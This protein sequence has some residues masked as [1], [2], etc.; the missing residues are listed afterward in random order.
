MKT[1]MLAAVAALALTSSAFA[2]DE[3]MA[4]RFGNTTKVTYP[5]NMV[6]KIWY[7]ADHTFTGDANGNAIGGT[8]QVDGAKICV[9]TTTGAVPNMPATQCNPVAERKVGETWTLGEGAQQIKVE[10][11]AGKQ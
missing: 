8:W 3:V 5:G 6:V 9:S 7:A 2:G 1:M 11:L 10:L 4:S